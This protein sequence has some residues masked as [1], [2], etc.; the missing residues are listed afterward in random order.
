[1]P[2]ATAR[3]A[4]EVTGIPTTPNMCAMPPRERDLATSWLQSIDDVLF[5]VWKWDRWKVDS[6]PIVNFDPTP[7]EKIQAWFDSSIPFFNG[8]VDEDGKGCGD[9]SILVSKDNS[10]DEDCNVCE[11]ASA[12]LSKYEIVND[13]LVDEDCNLCEDASASLSKD[14]AVNEKAVGNNDKL[15]LED[16]DGLFDIEAG[17]RNSEED[18]ENQPANVSMRDLYAVIKVHAFFCKFRVKH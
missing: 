10:V 8:I 1:M 15:L 13:K 3:V 12:G 7:A 16:R 6:I 5:R 11:D 9:D 14:N 17:C 2:R 4:K 18:N